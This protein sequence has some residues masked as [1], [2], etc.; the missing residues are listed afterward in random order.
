MD[1]LRVVLVVERDKQ[2]LDDRL[3]QQDGRHS[4]KHLVETGRKRVRTCRRRVEIGSEE[5]VVLT[6]V[7]SQR[8]GV[9]ETVVGRVTD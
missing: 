6:R 1:S 3:E 9:V 8:P 2:R 4:A 7:E 5:E